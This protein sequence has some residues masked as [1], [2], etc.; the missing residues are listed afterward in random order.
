MSEQNIVVFEWDR[1]EIASVIIKEL[2]AHSLRSLESQRTQ[3]LFIL[4]FSVDPAK[5]DRDAGKQ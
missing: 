2:T 5:R 1:F 4:L 3:S